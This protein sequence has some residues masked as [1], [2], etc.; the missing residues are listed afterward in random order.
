ME[1]N[2]I[3]AMGID[4]AIGKEGDLIWHIPEDLKHF[5]A[6]TTGHPVIMGRKTWESLPK[7]PL[8]GRRNIVLTR[9]QE[10]ETPGAEKADSIETALEITSEENPFIIGGAEVYKAALPFVTKLHLTIVEDKCDNADA[11]FQ[12]PLDS[13]KKIEESALQTSSVTSSPRFRYQTYIRTNLSK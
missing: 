8:P 11:F 1:V 10:Y 3:V 2:M 12:I 7:R 9:Q 13:F 4:G 5:K 6:L